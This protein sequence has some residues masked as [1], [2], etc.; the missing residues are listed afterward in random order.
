MRVAILTTDGRGTY[1]PLDLPQPSFGTA[2]EALIQGFS[3]LP[4]IEVHVISC[5]QR[6]IPSPQTELARNAKHHALYVPKVGWLRTGY[7]GCIRAVRAKLREINPDIVHGQG[8]ERDCAMSAV[9][10]GFPNVVTVHGN[11]R[12]IARINRVRPLGYEW[13]A[14]RLETFT[15]PRTAGIVCITKYT[16]AAVAD[17]ARR[18]WVVP[19][20]VDE[21][22][23]AIE[24]HRGETPTVLCVGNIQSRKNQ[25]V[26]IRA[27][28]E[29][30]AKKSI[31]VVFAG[32]A[33]QGDA[34]AG[35]FF[36]LVK[37]RPWCVHAGHLKRDELKQHLSR[38]TALALPSLEDNCPMVVLEA[39]AAGVPVIAAAVGGV[40]EL[41]EHGRNGL[42]C[43]PLDAASMR[44]QVLTLLG[45]DAL[46]TELARAGKISAQERFHPV[47]IARQHVV[48]Y[49]EVLE[50]RA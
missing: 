18:T 29:I 50:T 24:R 8:T 35:E 46:A 2:P 48:I 1:V 33:A 9:F 14:A 38:A 31:R 12:L 11:M 40:P 22:F 23:F 37:E 4:Q 44:E 19:N 32:H 30:A 26:F 41:V 42:L 27:L 15:L 20:A 43:D 21:T 39:M 13:L 49:R 28:D 3:K 17:L 6:R 36:A 45:D 16:Q 5:L 7:Q 34:Y 47:A 10:S 25:N